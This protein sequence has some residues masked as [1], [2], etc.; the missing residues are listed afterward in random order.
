MIIVEG[1]RDGGKV[2]FGRA[3]CFENL[4]LENF[5]YEVIRGT[6]CI[7]FDVRETSPGSHGPETEYYRT[8]SY[9]VSFRHYPI[10][11]YGTHASSPE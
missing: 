3:D 2:K 11:C 4:D 1:H 5:I 6:V 9:A 10:L 7:D 8:G